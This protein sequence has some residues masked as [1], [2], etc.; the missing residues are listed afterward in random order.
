MLCSVGVEATAAVLQLVADRISTENQLN[1][2]SIVDA[3]G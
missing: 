1:A 3:P 2:V